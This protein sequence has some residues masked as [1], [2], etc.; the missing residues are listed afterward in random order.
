MLE[1]VR[2][3]AWRRCPQCGESN[4]G[5]LEECRE[6]QLMSG[7]ASLVA[8]VSAFPFEGR[9]GIDPSSS[10]I[11]GSMLRFDFRSLWLKPGES[12]EIY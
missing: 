1:R 6:C 4:V 9:S 12:T 3:V 11:A 8:A 5:M 7:K 2:Y 10:S